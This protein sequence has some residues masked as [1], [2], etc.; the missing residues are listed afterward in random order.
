MGGRCTKKRVISLFWWS[1]GTSFEIYASFPNAYIII[2]KESKISMQD[3][4]QRVQNWGTTPYSPLS[5]CLDMNNMISPNEFSE[6]HIQC[7][8]AFL[9][10]WS[11]WIM[12]KIYKDWTIFTILPPKKRYELTNLEKFSKYPKTIQH[13]FPACYSHLV[14]I[15]ANLSRKV[16]PLIRFAEIVEIALIL[17][18]VMRKWP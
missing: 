18:Q 12:T 15:L 2:K 17:P 11:L 3:L 5:R 7:Q 1:F 13:C 4:W 9:I 16:R 10:F 6:V 14:Q 8:V